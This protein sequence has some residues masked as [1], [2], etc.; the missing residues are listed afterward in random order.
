MARRPAKT[1]NQL[2]HYWQLGAR[3][4]E[5]GAD[6]TGSRDATWP[7]AVKWLGDEPTWSDGGA[8]KV[9][10]VAFYWDGTNYWGQGTAWES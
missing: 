7:A 6:G 10:I 2:A 3:D 1:P 5:Q 4:R 9:M 8:N